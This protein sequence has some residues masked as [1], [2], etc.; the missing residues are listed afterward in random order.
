MTDK[1]DNF[2]PLLSG[3][4]DACDK[5]PA[6]RGSLGHPAAPAAGER[7]PIRS[8]QTLEQRLHEVLR[9]AERHTELASA[10]LKEHSIAPQDALRE[11][12]IDSLRDGVALLDRGSVGECFT[13]R[14]AGVA[15]ASSPSVQ[16]V[17][18]SPCSRDAVLPLSGSRRFGELGLSRSRALEDVASL[19]RSAATTVSAAGLRERTPQPQGFSPSRSYCKKKS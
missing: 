1:S 12:F 8:R 14:Q 4:P 7:E 15:Q 13:G 17:P 5:E 11:R 19:H 3:F 16:A 18:K 2:V 10:L 6:T 9:W